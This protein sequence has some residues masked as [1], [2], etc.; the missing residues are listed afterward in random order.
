M[1]KM[2]FIC[3][4]LIIINLEIAQ[5]GKCGSDK[6]KIEPMN[7][8]IKKE[9]KTNLAHLPNPNSYSPIAIGFDF[10]TFIKP[11][12]LSDSNF[13]KLKSALK[14]TRVEFSKILQ[15]FHQ[16]FD[17]TNYR[18]DLM[19]RCGITTIGENY[20]NFL[21]TNDLI[22]FPVI[23]DNIDSTIS[24]TFCLTKGS[25]QP[26]AG[27]LNINSRK[28]NFQ[29]S[30]ID[31]YLKNLIFHGIMHI[32]GFDE[33]IFKNKNMI[34]TKGSISY[35]KS[36]NV[37]DKAKEHFGCSTITGIPLDNGL[38]H[39]DGRI[40]FE[41]SMVNLEFPEYIISDITLAALEDTGFY[42]VN[43]Y[44]GGIFKFGKN[45]G[46]DFLTKDCII[47]GKASFEEF[48]T[49]E[50]EPKCS[51]SRTLKSSCYIQEY[52]SNL[53]SAYQYFS[54]PKK[55]GLKEANYCPLPYENYY[56]RVSYFPDH[57]QFGISGSDSYGEK[58]GK[59][60]LCFMSSL[61]P[62]SST[63]DETNEIPI[64]YEVECDT[65][66]KNIIIKIDSQRITCPTKKGPFTPSG[67]KGSIECPEFSEIC[68][69]NNGLVCNEMF[70]CFTEMAN[71][72]NYNYII[73]Y[74]DYEGSPYNPI[75]PPI[76]PDDDDDDTIKPSPPPSSDSSCG[77]LGWKVA[78]II[79][80]LILVY[81]KNK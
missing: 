8:Q 76:P 44:S 55:G 60:S 3:I 69:S 28:I 35:I 38:S 57:C 47:N 77:L 6:L 32:L 78:L 23:T 52:S 74:Y 70:T 50:D 61:I 14:G 71:K 53:P 39:W 80:S 37:L 26:I 21:K 1:K 40:M 81:V 58:I 66:K 30:N 73:S 4:M 22:I 62:S 18:N 41:D 20:P 72:N 51:S 34:E 65:S 42:K 9:S 79:A 29:L 17:L 5:C 15:V 19:Q 56:N 31:L 63:E 27:V 54:D 59:E 67:F 46:C 10:T 13:S 25:S 75:P 16:E 64:C 33:D 68:S 7:I 11:S 24:S 43:Y 2:T 12:S 49:V 48:C 45:K 36:K